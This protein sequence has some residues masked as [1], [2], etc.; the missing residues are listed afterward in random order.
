MDGRYLC[1]NMAPGRVGRA[2]DS[3]L[4]GVVAKGGLDGEGHDGWVANR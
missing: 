1:D 2:G 3:K 4:P